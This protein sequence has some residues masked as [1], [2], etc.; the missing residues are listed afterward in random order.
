ME[1]PQS[2]AGRQPL[3]VLV[4]LA[5]CAL[6]PHFASAQGLTGTLI[7][8]VRDGQGG[9]IPGAL[10]R[11]ASPSLISR[12][13]RA[14]TTEKGQLRFPS[15]P[16][17]SYSIDVEMAG[18]RPVSRGRHR[19]WRRRNHRENRRVEVGADR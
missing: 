10:V 3:H 13:L 9:V 8:S 4:L 16:P 15:L 12:E 19:Y 5:S 18:V 2:T 7:G 1:A 17:G 6:I 14:T 11:V